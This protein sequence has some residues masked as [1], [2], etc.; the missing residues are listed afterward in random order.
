MFISLVSFIFVIGVCVIVHEYGHY[1]TAK[2]LG[3]QVHEFSV[4]MGKLIYQ[5]QDSEGML[6]SLRVLPIGGFVRIAG[7]GSEKEEHEE[8]VKPGMGFNDKPAWKRFLILANGSAMNIV[9]AIL[10]TATFLYGYGVIDMQSTRIGTIMPDFPAESA[11][12]LPN[13]RIIEINSKIVEDW[14]SMTTGIRENAVAGSV[15]FK[16]ERDG[17]ILDIDVIIPVH[18]ESGVPMLGIT[19]SRR[20]YTLIGAITNAG[21]YIVYISVETLRAIFNLIA[22]REPVDVAGP[23]GIASMAGQA[24]RA[25]VW[26][27]VTFLALISLNLGILNLFPFPALDGGRLFLLIGE[28]IFRRRLPEKVEHYIHFTGLVLLLSLIVFV[29]WQ[30]IVRLMQ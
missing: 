1:K 25:G 13:D 24:A 29:T 28:M 4:G 8:V 20:T 7:M 11:G 2:M 16:I 6:W 26:N 14:R 21:G 9:L 23:V 19:P 17:R 27:F 3:V 12:F 5:K 18:Q 22:V 30:D 10:L 15:N